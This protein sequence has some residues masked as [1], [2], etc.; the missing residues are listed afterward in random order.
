V[1]GAQPL[2]AVDAASRCE[3]G[4]QPLPASPTP[5]RWADGAA[6]RRCAQFPQ[7]SAESSWQLVSLCRLETLQ[8]NRPRPVLDL[9]SGMDEDNHDPEDKLL[10]TDGQ[11]QAVIKPQSLG[12]VLES[13]GHPPQEVELWK[14]TTQPISVVDFL[15]IIACKLDVQSNGKLD[16]ERVQAAFKAL[17]QKGDGLLSPDELKS[18]MLNWHSTLGRFGLEEFCIKLTDV[19]VE[20]MICC[21]DADGDGLVSY[22]EFLKVLQKVASAE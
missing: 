18:S 6:D 20:A 17:N 9:L 19:E 2:P 14:M 1:A 12:N 22:E 15:A 13:L 10:V 16:T 7:L 11:G 8:T 3:A 5:L 4:T 21:A